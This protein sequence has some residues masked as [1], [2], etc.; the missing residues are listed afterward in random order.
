MT[1][2]DTLLEKLA[3]WRFDSER[4]T[5]TVH[6]PETGW[7]ASVVADCAAL[8]GCRLW[9]LNLSRADDAPAVD[10]LKARA[11]RLAARATGLL[12]PLRLIEVDA[13]R[14]TALLRSEEPGRRGD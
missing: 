7:T 10:G 2:D 5:L 6:H 11:E 12:E 3:E 8:V 9:E 4:R 1:L 13:E 14:Q